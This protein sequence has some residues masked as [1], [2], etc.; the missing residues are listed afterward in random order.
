MTDSSIT[1]LAAALRESFEASRHTVI[2]DIL[3][4]WPENPSP[5]ASS[6]APSTLPVLAFLETACRTASPAHRPLTDALLDAAPKLYWGQTYSKAD[7][8]NGFLDRYGWTSIVGPNAPVYSPSLI[9]G[10][11]FLG[12]DVEY[13]FHKH[14]AEEIYQVVSGTAS[15]KLGEADWTALEAGTVVHN[16]PWRP[17]GMRTDHGQPLLLAYLWRAGAVEKSVMV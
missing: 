11:L 6:P 16:P 14:S 2:R 15:W 1:G 5:P 17:H 3:S 13:P 7:F 8:D 12:P 9:S 10:F 4:G